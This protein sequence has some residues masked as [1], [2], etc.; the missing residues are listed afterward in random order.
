MPV[1]KRT[2]ELPY[3]AEDLIDLVS[4]VGRYPDFI[5]WIKRLRIL[6]DEE[7]S[8][9]LSIRAEAE[10]GFL[11][12]TERFTTDV[13]TDRRD[14]T[15]DVS[16]V[17]GP[18]KRLKNRWAFEPLEHGTRVDF[19]IDFQFRNIIL[20]SL[21]SANLDFAVE[22]IIGAFEEEAARRYSVIDDEPSD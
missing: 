3:R 10:V 22:R 19:F 11:T 2:L 20:Q 1:L 7:T 12:F 14:R 8:D 17:R 18:F 16:L 15:I 6:D 13:L 21:A 5:K 9:R 4:G